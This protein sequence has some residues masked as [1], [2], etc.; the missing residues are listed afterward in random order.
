MLYNDAAMFENLVGNFSHILPVGV[1]WYGGD[2]RQTAQ[3]TLGRL[4]YAN[5][6]QPSFHFSNAYIKESS[7]TCL[8]NVSVIRRSLAAD[9]SP[10]LSDL[11][12]R[13]RTHTLNKQLFNQ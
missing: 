10:R 11:V 6:R 12:Q 3:G 8:M 5:V 1:V 9:G 13:D 4:K 7:L 2:M